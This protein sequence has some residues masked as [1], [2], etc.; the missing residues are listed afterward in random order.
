V[1]EQESGYLSYLLRLWQENKRV[2]GCPGGKERRHH[3]AVNA[4][5]RVSLESSLTGSVHGFASLDDAVAFLR[6]QTGEVS[7][8]DDA[9]VPIESQ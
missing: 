3:T 7:D 4:V 8:T 2:P 9:E 1:S 5:W 6:R